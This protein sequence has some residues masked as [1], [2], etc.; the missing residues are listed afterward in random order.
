MV[1][2]TEANYANPAFES[3][4]ASMEEGTSFLNFLDQQFLPPLDSAVNEEVQALFAGI[5][6]AAEVADN[7]EQNAQDNLDE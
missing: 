6:S 1:A 3:I 7:L 4:A 5:S 2:G